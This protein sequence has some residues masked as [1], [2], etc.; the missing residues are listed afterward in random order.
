MMYN[1]VAQPERGHVRLVTGDGVS[2]CVWF[3]SAW[4]AFLLFYYVAPSAL[5]RPGILL[6]CLMNPG[7]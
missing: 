7:L 4:Y 2:D 6:S 1:C 5:L 3:A